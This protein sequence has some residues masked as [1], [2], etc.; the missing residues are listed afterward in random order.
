MWIH[1]DLHAENFGTYMNSEGVLVFDVNDFDEAYLGHF[2]WDLRRFVAS[3]ALMGWQKALPEEDVRDLAADYLQR[4][5]RP[6]PPLR[7]GGPTTR[8]FALRLDNTDGADPRGAAGGPAVDPGRACSTSITEVVDDDAGSSGRRG[9]RSSSKTEREQGRGGVQPLPRRRSRTRKREHQDG[10]LRRQGRR[11]AEGLRDR[12]RR[13][14]RRTTCLIEGCNQALE[15]DIVLT[16]EAGQRRRG[17]PGR[18]RQAR[19]RTSSS[20]RDTARS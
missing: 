12:Q 1:G 19:P 15:N 10:L 17:Q 5:R 13:A 4:V 2:T 11:R 8:R 9:A 16:H 20:T 6:G 7:R 14:C 3:L 18:R